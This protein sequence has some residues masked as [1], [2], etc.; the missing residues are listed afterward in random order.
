MALGP[1]GRLLR[2]LDLSAGQRRQI[3][4]LVDEAREGGLLQAG[5]AL[6]EARQALERALWHAEDD[7]V[8]VRA[9]RAAAA[10]A[11]DRLFGLRRGLARDVLQV[12]TEDQRA[13][14]L[15]ALDE[16]PAWGPPRP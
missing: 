16:T 4:S 3:R 13:E 14:L 12:L 1:A 9:L 7:D 2:D 5:E 11:E 8:A 10:E 6:H 15:R